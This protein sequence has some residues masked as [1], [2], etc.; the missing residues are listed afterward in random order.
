MS[1]HK[2]GIVKDG[3]RR[4][5]YMGNGFYRIFCEYLDRL[6]ILSLS[7]QK[8]PSG[9]VKKVMNI[10]PDFLNSKINYYLKNNLIDLNTAN[11]IV[12]NFNRIWNLMQKEYC[13]YFSQGD[14]D[15]IA[16][17]AGKNI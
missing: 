4:E 11:Q 2:V 13:A 15:G 7:N 14:I 17:R 1:D 5:N 10:L 9:E 8:L 16:R 6:F 3:I 12:D